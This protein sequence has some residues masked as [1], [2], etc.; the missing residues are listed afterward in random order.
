MAEPS[1]GFF[2]GCA[3]CTNQE[4]DAAL[5]DETSLQNFY[6]VM[7]QRYMSNGVIGAG[8]V[9]KD[10]E[11]AVTL[12]PSVKKDK[13]YSDLVV[14]IS[15]V[16]AVRSFLATNSAMK[17][18]S[19]NATP[20]AVYL[21]GTQWPKEVQQFKFAAFGMA[22]FNSSDL[23]LQ[24]GS[25]YVGVSLKKKP[26]GTAPDPTLI[27]KAFD[28][29]LNGSQFAPIKAQ[30]QQAR[31]QF[32]A[33]VIKDALIT[34]PLV[35]LAQLPDGS[36]PRNA[37]PEKLWS[38]RI[39]I[40]KNGKIQTVP[41]IN[42]KDVS[43][44]GDPTLLNSR[45]VDTKTTNAMRDYVNTRLGKVGNQPN[46]LYKQFLTIIK[47]NQQL[48]A[49]T[50]INLILKKQLMDEMSEY[51]RN[52][53]EFILTTGVGQVT[54]SKSNGMNI[55]E[56]SGTCIGIDSVALALAYLRR[57]PKTIDI[58]TAKTE[59]S[60]AA[61]LFFKVRAGTLDLLE[62]ELRY[63]G[64]FKSQPQFQAFLSPQFKSL[65]KG[66]FGNARNIIFG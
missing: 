51:T 22:D 48:F 11:K 50:L 16:K 21:T 7:Y 28:T 24:Y 41:L 31:Q 53:F 20:N 64:D 25:N 47:R 3:L 63:K 26:K 29:V 43:A 34:G 60:N 65:L 6:N 62:L 2:A 19:G 27:N 49:D 40:Y 18:I 30:L 42:L 37:P 5:K 61:K 23:I 15:A 59:S 44:I 54:I 1:E 36:N 45:E 9:K 33:G 57:Q 17:G 8:N 56:G 52:N 39:G 13:F 55:Q 10:F 58:D 66:D 38:T 32:F 14:G 46:T 4:M 12:G 35:G